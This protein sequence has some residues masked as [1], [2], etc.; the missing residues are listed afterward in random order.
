MR[1]CTGFGLMTCS[2]ETGFTG[3]PLPLADL[4]LRAERRP[5]TVVVLDIAACFWGYAR[6]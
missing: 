5:G 3:T 2:K 6:R 1:A 4:Y